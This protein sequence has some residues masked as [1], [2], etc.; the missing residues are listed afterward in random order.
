[1]RVAELW[2]YPV[3]GLRGEALER[4]EIAAAGI[5]GD[6]AVRVAD[7]RGTVTGR[8]KQR[9]IR[10]PATLGDGGEPLVAGE[11]WTTEAA[12]TA[13]REVAGEGASLVAADGGHAFD[14]AP[15]LVV[16]D[17]GLAQLGYD[18]RRFR[19]NIVI[20]GV[21]GAAE[22]DWVRG[23]VRVGDA[24]LFVEEGCERCV[25]TTID[26]DT[27]A[28]DPDVLRRARLELGGMMGVYCSV[29]QPGAVAVG[30]QVT[31]VD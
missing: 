18:R 4:L 19:P 28:V 13:V 25:I 31:V 30:D 21:D 5:P 16:T 11:H 17:G 3:K 2:R 12:A 6:R 27:T 26:P 10:L 23:R 20:E 22:Q 24:L 9:M 8:R 14:A 1:M 15:I 7:D 29:L